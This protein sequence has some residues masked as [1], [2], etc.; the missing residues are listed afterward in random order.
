MFSEEEFEFDIEQISNFNENVTNIKNID[1]EEIEETIEDIKETV[2]YFTIHLAIKVDNIY[3]STVSVEYPSTS[4]QNDK[5]PSG[6]ATKYNVLNLKDYDN[7]S[8]QAQNITQVQ[9]D[10]KKKHMLLGTGSQTKVKCPFFGNI[11]VTKDQKK[12]QDVTI[13]SYI[14]DQIRSAKHSQLE[15]LSCDVKFY[16]FTPVNLLE[17]PFVVLVCI[18][19]HT[20]PPP[21]PHHVSEAIQNHLKTLI[22]EASN[23]LEHVT[24]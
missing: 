16:R 24:S 8:N 7:N 13:C 1:T 21:P 9:E 4:P 10:L 20:Y 6:F 18:E 5:K 14:N 12:C 2:A 23:N 17:C 11:N 19:E 3:Y 15:H 22:E